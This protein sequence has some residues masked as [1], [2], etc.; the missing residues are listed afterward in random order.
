LLAHHSVTHLTEWRARRFGLTASTWRIAT[1]EWSA[2][3]DLPAGNRYDKVDS[4]QPRE[5]IRPIA[6]HI[7][8]LP[9]HER[10]DW[11]HCCSL[12]AAIVN[13]DMAE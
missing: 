1:L 9:W 11:M 4:I 6:E 12:L 2:A 8:E 10:S 13:L 5:S 3:N 7:S